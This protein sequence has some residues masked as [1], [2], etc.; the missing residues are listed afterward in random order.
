MTIKLADL[1][2]PEKSLH[3]YCGEYNMDLIPLY[4]RTLQRTEGARSLYPQ[5]LR[6]QVEMKVVS[7]V[8]FAAREAIEM[9]MIPQ[10]VEFRCG[11]LKGGKPTADE[12]GNRF[13]VTLEYNT[14]GYLMTLGG[15]EHLD[16]SMEWQLYMD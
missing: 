12:W 2:L 10:V 13:F 14:H 6:R 7:A 5:L 16:G 8:R 11:P 15:H 3:S 1:H 9:N 4:V